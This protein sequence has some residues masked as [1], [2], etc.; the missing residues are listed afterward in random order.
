MQKTIKYAMVALL[1]IIAIA[2]CKKEINWNARLDPNANPNN[3]KP[4]PSSEY[5]LSYKVDG[6]SVVAKEFSA[7]RNVSSVPRTLTVVGTAAGGNSPKF[8]F[9][10]EE[11]IIGFVKGLNIG[12]HRGTSPS[13]YIEYTNNLGTFFSTENDSDGIYLFIADISYVNGGFIK[14]TFNGS[15]KTDK[16]NVVQ[17]TEGKLNVKFN[18]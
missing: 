15:I 18:N 12:N 14:C 3:E 13:N 17:I 16:G 10:A 5:Y 8:K 2:G 7:V 6:V 9:Y 1:A 4:D 11:S